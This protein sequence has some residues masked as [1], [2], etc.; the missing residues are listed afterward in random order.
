MPIAKCKGSNCKSEFQ[1]KLYGS[2][3]VHNLMKNGSW[4]CTVCG[5]VIRKDGD[6]KKKK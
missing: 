3:R 4:R 2:K 1:D 5:E 6:D